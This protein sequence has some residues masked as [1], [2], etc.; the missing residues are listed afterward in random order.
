MFSLPIY[1]QTDFPFELA[2][3]PFRETEASLL[4]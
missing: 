4:N 3:L 2:D 1:P